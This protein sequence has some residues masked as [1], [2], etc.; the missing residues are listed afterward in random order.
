MAWAD[1]EAT[2]WTRD[3]PA[4]S[5]ARHCPGV[6]TFILGHGGKLVECE[7]VLRM[8]AGTAATPRGDAEK[9]AG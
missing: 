4:G 8:A 6:I 7:T 9:G 3:A 2:S 5:E 1:L